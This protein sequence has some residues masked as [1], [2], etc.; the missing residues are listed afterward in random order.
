MTNDYLTIVI[1]ILLHCQL[2]SYSFIIIYLSIHIFKLFI[3]TFKTKSCS[4]M[5]KV[6]EIF[7]E[8]VHLK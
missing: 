1:F 5:K 8:I 7:N 3:M 2:L 6:K 4:H